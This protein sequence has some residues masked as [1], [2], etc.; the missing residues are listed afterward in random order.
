MRF[1]TRWAVLAVLLLAP[2]VPAPHAAAQAPLPSIAE[3]T[4]GMERRDGFVPVYW[5]AS[6]GKLWMEVPRTGEELIYVVSLPAGLGS[7]DIGL[8]R[9]QI[10]GE[11]LVRFDRVGPRVLLV[12]PNQAYR[13]VSPDENERRA[14]EQSFAQSVLW[15]FTVAAE[16]DGR[17]LVDATDF[18]LRDAHGVVA[19]LRRSRQGDYRLDA[20][21]SALYLQNTRGFPRNTE[22]EATLTF[23]GD[24]PGSLVRD[25]TPTP[26]AITLRQ[27][28]SFV[29]LPPP[30]Y[31]PRRSD[32][33]GGFFGISYFDY[34]T[35][36]G[37]DIVQRMI[38]RHRL[39]KRD[40]SAAMSEAVE[41][42]VYYVDRGAPEPIRS[43]LLDGAR[44]WNQA[45]EAAGYRDA[46]R[47]ELLPEGADPMDVRYNV[48]QWVHR[49]TRGWSYGNTVTDPRTGEIIKGHVTLGS[50]RVRQ[51]YLIAEGLLAPYATGTERP[52]ELE[53]MA[54]ARI[55]QLAAHE[56]GHTLGLVHNY[57]ASAQ[58]RAS[59]MDYPHPLV[60]LR[61]DGTIDLSE[62]YTAE[63]GPW[64]KVAITWGYRDPPAGAN[65]QAALDAVLA[66]A[67]ARGITLLTDQDARPAGSVSPVAHLWDNGADATAELRRT[68]RVRRAA[69]DRFG[70][71]AI[72]AGRP[73]ATLEEVLVPVYLHHRYQVEAASKALGGVDYTYAL[74]GDGQTPLTPVPA[75]QQRA[76]LD[77]LLATLDPAELAL[78]RPLLALIPPRPMTYDPTRELFDRWTGMGFDAISPATA[79]ADMTV[80]MILNPERAARLVEQG[81]LDR[82]MPNLEW[83]LNQL[84]ERTFRQRPDDEYLREIDRAVERVVVER[85]MVLAESA[86]MPQVRAT[87]QQVLLNIS[88]MITEHAVPYDAHGALLVSDI[89]RFVERPYQPQQR[90]AVPDAPPGQPI[91]SEDEF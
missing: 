5:D 42:I 44:W 54:L 25:V 23:T 33:R 73:L 13:A 91:G 32:P 64:D 43:A 75:A 38:S 58:G 17:V 67:R 41:P 79:A 85:L 48:I 9:G 31:R 34:A 19:A 22:I 65:E 36:V 18:V 21:R 30:G 12:Q 49:S 2:A 52:A 27:R 24:N 28:L 11:R 71:N 66:E 81:A 39:E 59:V 7:N 6:A 26:E 10:G 60:Q 78:P 88:R 14:V 76:A 87:A 45:F 72:R 89:K 86:P 16:T 63:I 3:K 37:E 15:G 35:P 4:R 51:D 68:M 82:R 62:A 40:P 70:Q 50:L 8:D 80:G 55:R 83:T 1:A 29:A 77:A 57:I 90:I 46:F 69:L 56:V 84:V 53:R 74:R 47:V 20:T 61:A